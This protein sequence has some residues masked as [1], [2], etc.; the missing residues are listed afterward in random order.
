MTGCINKAEQ[1]RGK[2]IL[3][4]REVEEL[5]ASF[6]VCFWSEKDV[7]YLV[8]ASEAGGGVEPGSG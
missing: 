4:N 1:E 3:T 7:D 5:R 8:A 2:Q 6:L